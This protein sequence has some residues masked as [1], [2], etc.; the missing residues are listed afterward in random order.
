MSPGIWYFHPEF[1]FYVHVLPRN[2]LI[3]RHGEVFNR[4]PQNIVDYNA[5]RLICYYRG[6]ENRLSNS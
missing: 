6:G 5:N 3:M 1:E 2:S 4:H